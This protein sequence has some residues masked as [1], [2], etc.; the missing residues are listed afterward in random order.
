MVLWSEWDDVAVLACGKLKYRG[1]ATQQ[2]IVIF[3]MIL[4]YH[5]YYFTCVSVSPF[6]LHDCGFFYTLTICVLLTLY[7]SAQTKFYLIHT[8]QKKFIH[9]YLIYRWGRGTKDV[10]ICP[11]SHNL[12]VPELKSNAEQ[13]DSYSQEG[14][15]WVILC[16][17]GH[18]I[19]GC[20]HH[21]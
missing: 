13:W 12:Q 16:I 17:T 2:I 9:Y 18:F 10:S 6:S 20:S 1:L 7:K 11:K 8:E 21:F 4:I 14:Q 5:H 19:L 3:T 15:S